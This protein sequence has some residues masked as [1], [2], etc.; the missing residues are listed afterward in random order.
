MVAPRVA[1]TCMR[2]I[3]EMYRN[4]LQN[5]CV[6]LMII[7]EH[8]TCVVLSEKQIKLQNTFNTYTNTTTNSRYNCNRSFRPCQNYSHSIFQALF[9]W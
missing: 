8:L 5:V 2:Q 7:M 9:C 4:K 3:G 6:G 1:A